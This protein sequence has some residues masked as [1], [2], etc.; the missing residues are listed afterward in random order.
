MPSPHPIDVHVGLR[1]RHRRRFLGSRSS[2]A[3]RNLCAVDARDRTD[4]HNF[5]RWWRRFS[6]AN[7]PK[8]ANPPPR[9]SSPW[10]IAGPTAS[11]PYA[12]TERD[13]AL[14]TVNVAVAGYFNYPWYVELNIH[15]VRRR[16]NTRETRKQI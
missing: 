3:A 8:K 2:I 10:P 13:G 16:G 15:L 12:R 5:P 11:E 14:A 7:G 6:L 4:M 9:R 1:I